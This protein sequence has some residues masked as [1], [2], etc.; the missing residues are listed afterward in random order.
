[1]SLSREGWGRGT[2]GK[3]IN[4]RGV[5]RRLLGE[6]VQFVGLEKL[7]RRVSYPMTGAVSP[8]GGSRLCDVKNLP[9]EL[10]KMSLDLRYD[11]NTVLVTSHVNR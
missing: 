9:G 10:Y 7:V 3:F 1:M 11:V 2:V 8:T 5:G 4:L 6:Q